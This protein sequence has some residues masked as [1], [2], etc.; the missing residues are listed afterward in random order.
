MVV[1]LGEQELGLGVAEDVAPLVER[2]AVVEGEPDRAESVDR[3]GGFEELRAVPQEQGDD[4]A[5]AD[6][7]CRQG[8]CEGC[9]AMAGLG[10]RGRLTLEGVRDRVGSVAGVSFESAE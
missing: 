10:V 4:V 5:P 6:A 3:E 8:S 9:H 1:G 7:L 2:Q